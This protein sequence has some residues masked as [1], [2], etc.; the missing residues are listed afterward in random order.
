M[1]ERTEYFRT[2]LFYFSLAAV[3]TRCLKTTEIYALTVLGAKSSKSRCLHDHA[4]LPRL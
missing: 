1:I 4:P 3:Q 2:S